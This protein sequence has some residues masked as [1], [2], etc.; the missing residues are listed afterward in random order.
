M[1]KINT[2]CYHYSDVMTKEKE[3]QLSM[4]G[5]THNESLDID[6]LMKDRSSHKHTVNQC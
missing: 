6:S 4:K 2:S 3:I 1:N 5:I